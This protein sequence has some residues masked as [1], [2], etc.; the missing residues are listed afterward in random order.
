MN[1]ICPAFNIVILPLESI[2]AIVGSDDAKDNAATME[3]KITKDKKKVI[4][5][6]KV[7]NKS[8]TK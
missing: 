4:L 6:Y 7:N 2:V 5:T 3:Y 8:A 1:L